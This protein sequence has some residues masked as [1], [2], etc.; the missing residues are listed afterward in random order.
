MFFWFCGNFE[1][2][3]K[4]GYFGIVLW[5]GGNEVV[6]Y[7]IFMLVVDEMYLFNVI[8]VLVW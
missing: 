3:F 1:D 7:L 4:F 5:D 2:L 6:G 8:V